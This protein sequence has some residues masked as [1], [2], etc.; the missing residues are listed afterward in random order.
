MASIH[1]IARRWTHADALMPVSVGDAKAHASLMDLSVL[2]SLASGS[3]QAGCGNL[4]VSQVV[5]RLAPFG[6]AVK[7]TSASVV[8]QTGAFFALLP[9]VAERQGTTVPVATAPA[10]VRNYKSISADLRP[11]NG[12]VETELV[13]TKGRKSGVPPRGRPDEKG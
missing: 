8:E 4:P 2:G 5:R 7:G 6:F 1:D 3:A 11:V 12:R 13:T 9:T 10:A